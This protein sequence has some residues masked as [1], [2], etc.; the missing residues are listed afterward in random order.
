[1]PGLK[2]SDLSVAGLKKFREL[3]SANGRLSSTDL[4]S[5]DAGLLEKLKLTESAYLKRSAALLFHEAPDRFITGAFIKI[6]FFVSESELA[7]HDEIHGPLFLQAHAV[8][9]LLR[10]KYMKAAISYHGLQR[11][12]RFPVP[13]D[14]LREAILNA[15]VH[16]DY[17]VPAPIQ[18]R[19]YEHKLKIW[20]PAILPD[21]WNLEKLLGAHASHPHNPDLANA[22]FRA[23]EIESWG[24]G[25]ERIFSACRDSKSPVPEIQLDG[26]D[27]WVEFPFS[28]T[29]ME[30]LQGDISSKNTEVKSSGKSSEVI[31]TM[32]RN[33]K[34]M[35]IPELAEAL[36]I[37]TRAVEK[38]IQKLQSAGRLKR[39]GPAKGGYWE[40]LKFKRVHTVSESIPSI[41][42]TNPRK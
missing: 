39:I 18:I 22:F 16:R 26:H 12:E 15:L 42:R 6:G 7:Y 24:R 40:I 29:Y 37:S 10:T 32:L 41:G 28:K 23:G 3:A 35:T 19:V 30:K 9:D 2:V 13:Y 4:S 31:I 17:A 11:I 38:N 27:L 14:A 1:M 25:M 21:G 5:S 36:S 20:N 8:V 34:T 33:N